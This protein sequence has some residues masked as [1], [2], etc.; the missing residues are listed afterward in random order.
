MDNYFFSRNHNLERKK[1][2]PQK[3]DQEK[4]INHVITNTNASQYAKCKPVIVFDIRELEELS[5]PDSDDL[6]A[7]C[8]TSVPLFVPH[9]N[10]E[11]QFP[12][13]NSYFEPHNNNMLTI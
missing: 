7:V 11:L 10:E 6:C 8:E 12:D 13:L 9:L 1:K 5:E 4:K 3:K 2:H